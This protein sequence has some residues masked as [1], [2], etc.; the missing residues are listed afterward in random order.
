M[1]KL[2][3]NTVSAVYFG[4][5]DIAARIAACGTYAPVHDDG[6]IL[7]ACRAMNVDFKIWQIFTQAPAAEVAA[8]V[9]SLN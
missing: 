7:I 2:S 5:S 4:Q 9:R 8:Q 3:V 6:K 1:N